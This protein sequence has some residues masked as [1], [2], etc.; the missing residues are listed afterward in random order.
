[1]GILA[2]LTTPFD[3]I[4]ITAAAGG[5]PPPL[6]NQL[7]ENGKIVAPVGR[8]DFQNLIV[9]LKQ[10]GDITYQ[11]ITPVRFVPMTGEA[12]RE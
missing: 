1:M 6:L 11:T 9:G 12:E 7:G 5:V 10:D 3:K 8:G 4:M 2:G